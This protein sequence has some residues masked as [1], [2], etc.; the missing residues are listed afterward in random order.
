[1]LIAAEAKRAAT[2]VSGVLHS[3]AEPPFERV[4]ALGRAP[5]EPDVGRDHR[6]L[7]PPRL[8]LPRELDGVPSLSVT[9]SGSL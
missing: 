2:N 3:G 8:Q 1:M 7:A 9:V 5:T 6:E 4:V